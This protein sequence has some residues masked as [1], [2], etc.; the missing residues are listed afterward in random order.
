MNIKQTYDYELIAK[1]NKSIHDWHFNL[2]PKYFKEYNFEASREFFKEAIEKENFIFIIG[3]VDKVPAGY[4]WL[5]IRNYPESKFIKSYSSIYVHH[6]S[7]EE[8]FKSKGY[9]SKLMKEIENIAASRNIHKIELDYW[10]ANR[11]A[12]QFYD[13]CGF[14][15]RRE[16]VYKDL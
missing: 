11:S 9:G 15:H 14:I 10:S 1:L 4:A 8:K 7:I 3:E 13:K 16:F 5:E 2:Y 6:F 12:S